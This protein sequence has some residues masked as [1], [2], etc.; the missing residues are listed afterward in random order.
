MKRLNITKE[1]YNKS[2]YFKN[3]YGKLEYVSESG[4]VFKTSKGKVLMFK[5]S[6]TGWVVGEQEW[7]VGDRVDINVWQVQWELDDDELASLPET[8]WTVKDAVRD[9]D[10]DDC[11]GFAYTI[12]HP[13]IEEE[14]MV[15]ASALFKP[16]KPV[17]KPKGR[18]LE[19][20]KKFGKKFGRK[21]G[22]KFAKESDESREYRMAIANA[23]EDLCVALRNYAEI[24]DKNQ[25]K[26][27]SDLDCKIDVIITRFLNETR[28]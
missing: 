6:D 13:G 12:A 26:K 9:D 15:S 20:T 18:T 27:A 22:R 16:S 28:L 2:R 23:C 19:S 1:Q 10:Y 25:A 7:N 17:R 24:L 4:N 5:E 14:F 3:K 21:F 11:D 8:G